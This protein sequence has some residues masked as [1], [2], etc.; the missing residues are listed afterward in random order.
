[1]LAVRV[2]DDREQIG[3]ALRPFDQRDIVMLS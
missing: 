1:M 3:T 2:G